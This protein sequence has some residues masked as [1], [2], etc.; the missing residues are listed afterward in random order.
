MMWYIC[1]SLH[2]EASAVQNLAREGSF[3]LE[4]HVVAMIAEIDLL[5]RMRIQ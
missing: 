2:V 4:R 3:A 1:H 5:C